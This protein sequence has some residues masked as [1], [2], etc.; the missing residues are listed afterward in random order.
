[1]LDL[2]GVRHA[3]LAKELDQFF[4]SPKLPVVV[5]TGHSNRMKELVTQIA[6]RYDFK[7]KESISNAGRLVIYG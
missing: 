3:D 4:T 6:H 1:M 5:I 7:V 2:H